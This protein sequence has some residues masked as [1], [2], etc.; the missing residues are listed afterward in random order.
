[1]RLL[2]RLPFTSLRLI[3]FHLSAS[4]PPCSTRFA[5]TA[6][7]TSDKKKAYSHTLLLPKTSFP[8][9]HKDVVSAEQA[10]RARTTDE[11][12]RWQKELGL[13]IWTTTAWSLPGNSGV[14]VNEEMEY[15]VVETK[16]GKLLLIA[17][18]RV[19]PMKEILGEFRTLGKL[20]G[21]DLVGTRYTHM[22]HPKTA[23]TPRP[24]IF[25]SSHVTSQS[26][27]GLVHSAP[28]HGYEDYQSFADAGILPADLR[29]PI[30]D[31]GKFTSALVGW[32]CDKSTE[33]LV[34]KEVLGD[35][36][37]AMINLLKEEGSLLAEEEIEHRYPCDWKTKER[38]IVRAT[39]Q[40]FAD[41][42]SIKKPALEAM[43]DVDF[44]PPKSRNRLES[45][46]LGRSE[47]CISR[48]RS[49]GVPIP[50]LY[51]QNGEP[52]LS[53]ESLAH[54]I[55][56]IEEK[57][58]DH[59]WSGP[60][61]DFVPPSQAGQT[62]TRG[63]DTLDVWFDSGSSWTLIQEAGLRSPAEPLADVYLEGSDQHRGWFQ[64]S[65]LTRLAAVK[66]G[67][68]GAPYQSLITHGMV[69]DEDGG[70]M[71]KSAGNGLSPMEVIHGSK[72]LPAFGADT[73]RLWAA[74]VDYAKDVSIGKS[75][76]SHAAETLRKLRNTS[77]FLL[78]NTANVPVKSIESVNLSFID[79]YVLHELSVLE[80]SAMEAYDSFAFNR[81]LLSLS[82]FA[83][84]TLSA[85]YFDCVKDILYSSSRTSTEREAIVATLYY[86]LQTLIRI[87]APIVPHLAEE[88]YEVSK[89]D[90]KSSLFKE[91]WTATLSQWKNN[92]VS[93]DMTSLLV[94]RSHVLALMEEAR[95]AKRMRSPAEAQL[96]ITG[97]EGLTRLLQR[98]ES[99]L[100]SLFGSSQVVLSSAMQSSAPW[101]Y[102]LDIETEL[103]SAKVGM[104]PSDGHKCPR[105]WL[106]SSKKADSLCGRC[107]EVVN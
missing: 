78:G 18:E 2:A 42:D 3:S 65:L 107:E 55:G 57:G 92:E 1:M 40:W 104:T 106:Y 76:L 27:T 41:V 100:P 72:D 6:V 43:D 69:L 28:A 31:D 86:T 67:E 63:T 12:Y 94:I 39:P 9:K 80:S 50:A 46:V 7:N 17:E 13:A 97:D 37:Q 22:F 82:T 79:K 54:I 51:L 105:C 60:M 23:T 74:S 75:S 56:V 68:A 29:C 5:S 20:C 84:S 48:Q 16:E 95:A 83:S 93:Q 35:G 11:L 19:L 32:S 73:L 30:D 91:H 26:G 45:F 24:S 52:L 38:I 33:T 14:S 36:I 89:K 49:W 71:S 10:Y 88:L 58:T 59:W 99:I 61:E 77:R 44:Y 66:E 70:K 53:S 81:V 98:H 101:S 90:V 103:G 64:S 21:R 96:S 102:A 15:V 85:F 47:W 4:L 8:L 34:G 62:L 87:M 25:L